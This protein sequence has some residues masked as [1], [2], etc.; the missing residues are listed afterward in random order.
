MATE[1]FHLTTLTR[2][3]DEDLRLLE[4]LGVPE[5]S[6]LDESDPRCTVALRAK[7]TSILENPS[8]SP[9]LNLYHRRFGTE[10]QLDE[11]EV[12]FRP[13]KRRLDWVEPVT[14]RVRLARW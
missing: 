14:L 10:V 8:L 7:A 3:P 4:A 5:I 11:V 1:V 2:F 12:T 13:P 6:A 9:P